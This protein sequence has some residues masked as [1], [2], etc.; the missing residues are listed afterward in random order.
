MAERPF[1]AADPEAVRERKRTAKDALEVQRE[2]LGKLLKV[3][4]FRRYV[5]RL[6][7]RCKLLESPHSANGSLQSVNIGRQDV[8]RELWAEIESADPF[9]IPEMMVE[10]H[11]ER[12]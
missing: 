12:G 3:P 11:K 6:I 4:E 2:E 8:G 9:A 1:N 10:H 5:W 7:G